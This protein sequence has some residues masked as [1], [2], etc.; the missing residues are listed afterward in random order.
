MRSVSGLQNW[1]RIWDLHYNSEESEQRKCAVRQQLK[2]SLAFLL[3][4]F[5]K[6]SFLPCWE[7]AQTWAFNCSIYGLCSTQRRGVLSNSAYSVLPLPL[8]SIMVFRLWRGWNINLISEDKFTF[9]SKHLNLMKV[10][11]C[12][13]VFNYARGRAEI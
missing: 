6:I 9:H 5:F 2:I 8:S 13:W 1:M 12:W 10:L 7:V 11:C 3:F 4:I